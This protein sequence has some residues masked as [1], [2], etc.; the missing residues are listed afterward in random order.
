M[1]FPE[2]VISVSV[3]ISLG[4]IWV[5]RSRIPFIFTYNQWMKLMR[6]RKKV[7]QGP[8]A[9]AMEGLKKRK[10]H[11]EAPMSVAV[12]EN[13]APMLAVANAITTAVKEFVTIA[14]R[15]SLN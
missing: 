3:N 6:K 9:D 12:L 10:R 13:I 8:V 5:Y 15:T 4:R 1:R 11:T 2:Y 14:T 7:G